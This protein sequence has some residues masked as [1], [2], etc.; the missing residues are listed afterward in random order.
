[1]SE[2]H[3]LIS[4]LPF[5][6]RIWMHVPQRIQKTRLG[7]KFYDRFIPH[8]IETNSQDSTAMPLVVTLNQTIRSEQLPSRKMSDIKKYDHGPVLQTQVV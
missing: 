7:V 2:R 1:M 6:S 4:D 3:W 8:H 5:L